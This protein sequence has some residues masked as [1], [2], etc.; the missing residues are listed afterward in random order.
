MVNGDDVRDPKVIFE[1]K[2]GVEKLTGGLTLLTPEDCG[3]YF[4]IY[5]YI[6]YAFRL[7]LGDDG[8]YVY[9]TRLAW[10]MGTMYETP[11]VIFEKMMG[12]EKLTEGFNP[13]NP[14]RLNHWTMYV[15]HCRH[16]RGDIGPNEKVDVGLSSA[17]EY[18]GPKRSKKYFCGGRNF[19]VFVEISVMKNI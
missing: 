4:I 16:T 17:S 14:Q 9:N 19:R 18:S 10:L 11:K 5:I 12:V 13:P 1:K 7:V 15:F 6:F 8:K 3:Y 2:L